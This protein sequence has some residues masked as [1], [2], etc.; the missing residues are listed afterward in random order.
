L[1]PKLIKRLAYPIH[2]DAIMTAEADK[3][4]D[5]DDDIYASILS[6][7]KEGASKKDISEAFSISYQQLR[8]LTAELVDQEMLRLDVK[9]RVFVTTDKGHVFLQNR[10]ARDV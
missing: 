4:D 7:A 2:D 3:N 8:R 6:F 9:K 1:L 10:K 5:D